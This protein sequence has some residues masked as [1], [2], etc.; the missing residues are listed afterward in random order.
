MGLLVQDVVPND[1]EP[2]A[3]EQATFQKD[4]GDRSV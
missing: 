3:Q 1:G 2:N 4:W